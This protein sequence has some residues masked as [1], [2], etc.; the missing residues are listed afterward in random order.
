MCVNDHCYVL[1]GRSKSQDKYNNTDF[2]YESYYWENVPAKVFNVFKN[3]LWFGDANGHLCK[4]NSD[5]VGRT[6]YCDN[7]T[8]N[9]NDGGEIYM[10]GG[11]A[12]PCKWSTPLDDDDKPQYFKTLSK[13][14]SQLTM[15]PYDRTSAKVTLI[16]DGEIKSELGV[17]YADI[18]NWEV[19][20][21]ERFT[22]SSNDTAQDDFF[23][24]KVKKY[25]RLQ[26]LVEND[27]IYEPFG[28]LGI[29]KTYTFNNFSK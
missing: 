7:G 18:Q 28:I 20:D 17:F 23:K 15:L 9:V 13:R 19:V 1:D 16:K 10:T 27:A 24:R 12:I 4:F 11:V 6:K 22:F 5:V 14:G 29:T 2:L 8:A 21:F 3:E 25:K 26:I